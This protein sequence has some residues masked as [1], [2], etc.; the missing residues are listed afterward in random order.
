ML[1][2]F[3]RELAKT[4][5]SLKMVEQHTS[6]IADFAESALLAQAPPRALLDLTVADVRAYLEHGAT[7]PNAVSFRRFVQFLTTSG[8]LDYEQAEVLRSYLRYV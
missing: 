5:L 7:K 3:R 1:A 2:A 8:R 4:G 6:N